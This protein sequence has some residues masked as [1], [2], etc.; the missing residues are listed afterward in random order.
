MHIEAL[1]YGESGGLYASCTPPRPSAK[2][3]YSDLHRFSRAAAGSCV[4]F[5]LHSGSHTKLAGLP[6]LTR[7]RKR[8]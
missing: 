7:D 6:A 2:R 8:S 1:R 3:A 4:V 5:A